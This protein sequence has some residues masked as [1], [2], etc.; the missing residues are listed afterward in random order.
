[1][2]FFLKY[3]LF[4]FLFLLFSSYTT[5]AQHHSQDSTIIRQIL[6]EALEQDESYQMLDYISNKIGGSLSGSPG[7]Q[8]E[9]ELGAAALASLLYFLTEHGL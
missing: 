1:M 5:S 3:R 9:L 4:I 8:Q 2:Y 6:N 7:K